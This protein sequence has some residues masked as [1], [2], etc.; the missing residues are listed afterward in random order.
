[1]RWAGLG[2]RLS[3][4]S[5]SYQCTSFQ[6][7]AQ[8]RAIALAH[9]NVCVCVVFV[10]I[11]C[12]TTGATDSVDSR[13]EYIRTA[14]L[15][16][17]GGCRMV[18]HRYKRAWHHT[19]TQKTALLPPSACCVCVS[20]CL[21][22]SVHSKTSDPVHTYNDKYIPIHSHLLRRYICTKCKYINAYRVRH[23][24]SNTNQLIQCIE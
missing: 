14:A 2:V 3:M 5:I 8:W 22:C 12:Q 7:F 1:M 20:V 10:F 4:R 17:G 11:L 21:W 9:V 13:C 16:G 15:N 23:R 18:S 19:H 6:H 24:K